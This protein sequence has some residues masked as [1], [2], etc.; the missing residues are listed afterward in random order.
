MNNASLST[1][2]VNFW[3]VDDTMDI[4]SNTGSQPGPQDDLVNVQSNGGQFGG[5]ETIFETGQET[6]W[7]FPLFVFFV[8]FFFG[9]IVAY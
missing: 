3:T 9:V 2:V 5:L 7:G 6:R 1:G 8:S 4:S